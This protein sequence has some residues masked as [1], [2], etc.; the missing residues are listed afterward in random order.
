MGEHVA[1]ELDPAALRGGVRHLGDGGLRALMGIRDDELD[2]AQ[3]AP[4]ELAQELAQKVSASPGPIVR[5]RISRRPSPLTPTAMTKAT[6][7][8]RPFCRTFR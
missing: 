3:A 1:H 7:T 6:E 8:I 2:A 4:S 5:L